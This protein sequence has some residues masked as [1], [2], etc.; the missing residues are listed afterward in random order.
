MTTKH[1]GSS[2]E[3]AADSIPD[4]ESVEHHVFRD[5]MDRDLPFD[6]SIV[7]RFFW[8]TLTWLVIST[9]VGTYATALKIA[10]ELVTDPRIAFGRIE[11]V[12]KHLMLFGL[13]A[14]A[15]F[16]MVYYSVQRLCERPMFSW[17]L[18][19][20]HFWSWQILIAAGALTMPL[21]VTGSPAF[22][23]WQWP[24]DVSIAISWI[25]LFG[26]N[27]ALTI[28]KRR[29][30]ISYISIWFYG[31]A[32]VV[33]SVIELLALIQMDAN[34]WTSSPWTSGVSN[35]ALAS[36]HSH[37]LFM[38][39]VTV[40]L[41]GA[42]YYFV[43]KMVGQPIS[44]YPL[45]IVHFWSL[46]LIALWVAPRNLHYTAMPEWVTSVG[47]LTGIAILMPSIA[48]V[49]I[50]WQTIASGP[51]EKRSQ[52]S[53]R[54]VQASLLFYL[55]YIVLSTLQSF[56]VVD[57]AVHYTAWTSGMFYLWA[58]GF[59]SMMVIGIFYWLI[60]QI[61]QTPL[62]YPGLAKFHFYV[63]AAA[64]TL[65]IL[66]ALMA[67]VIESNYLLSL[68]QNGNLSNP[69]FQGV[70]PK[71]ADAWLYGAL[72]V[73]IYAGG[74]FFLVVNAI[75]TW[76]N[77]PAVY[78]KSRPH[79]IVDPPGTLPPVASEVSVLENQSGRTLDGVPVLDFARR[80]DRIRQ[81]Q[82]HDR[83]ERLPRRIMVPILIVTLL[84]FS[85]EVLPM[86]F[87]AQSDAAANR[88]L[89]LTPLEQIG[90]QIY[91]REGCVSC[92]SQTVR[93]LVAE[94]K[95]YGAPSD[96]LE[97]AHDNPTLWGDRRIGPDLAR[98]GGVNESLW[99]WNH[100]IDPRSIN[101]HSVMPRFEHLTRAA[102]DLS[103]VDEARLEAK[104]LDGATLT[105][106]GGK[107][108]SEIANAIA[109][110]IT[111]QAEAVAADIVSQGGPLSTAGVLTI[112]SEATALIS[113]LQRLG[114]PA[115]ITPSAET[116]PVTNQSEDVAST[117]ATI[118]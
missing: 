11:P 106:E 44:N 36:F 92:H 34:G 103:K 48:G 82:W 94:T 18:S 77:Q 30:P 79:P 55:A 69:E 87:M 24:I 93:P 58:I 64:T 51:T 13:L 59:A 27:V 70:L 112:E 104:Q 116:P 83:F 98:Q 31:A 9:V 32:I 17:G 72:G 15:V 80:I 107:T 118:Q 110:E 1:Q 66:S 84:A 47:M 35:A 117:E 96:R 73:T 54:F 108:N 45:A 61:F 105:G 75:A 20:L 23:H 60:P 28:A 43:P 5:A 81:L 49:V 74:L 109:L 111:R 100:L 78:S 95:R 29:S 52:A 2:S 21:G 25:A 99:H 101:E 8:A 56:K 3:L 113:Y 67:G 89:S 12:H 26:V 41:L 22:A 38:F 19:R 71:V 16:A 114:N 39:M 115:S 63:T 102:F 46:T 65:T 68:D 86:Y 76:A 7:R 50:G 57:A 42:M 10:P 53:T 91:R 97:F 6:D 40:P 90:R 4:H 88:H 62:V 85:V 33:V 37:N 14:N